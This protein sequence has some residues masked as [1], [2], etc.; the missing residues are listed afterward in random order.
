MVIFVFSVPVYPMK[1]FD[2]RA[3]AVDSLKNVD[4]FFLMDNST[5]S[6]NSCNKIFDPDQPLARKGLALELAIIKFYDEPNEVKNKK[7]LKIIGNAVRQ[8]VPITARHFILLDMKNRHSILLGMEKEFIHICPS[9]NSTSIFELTEDLFGNPW[10]GFTN[11]SK[12]NDIMNAIFQGEDE[13]QETF[14][15]IRSESRTRM[16]NTL[17]INVSEDIILAI[18]SW[19]QE[20][21][22]EKRTALIRQAEQKFRTKKPLFTLPFGIGTCFEKIM[23]NIAGKE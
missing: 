8:G 10:F 3:I 7:T 9:Q 11:K 19:L 13:R 23:Q 15:Y 16:H 4:P 2:C 17:E 18:L 22:E 12:K 21:D 14:T 5:I 1:E 6:C 20:P